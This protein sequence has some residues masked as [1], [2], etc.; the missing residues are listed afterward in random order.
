MTV[1]PPLLIDPA[2]FAEDA[3]APETHACNAEIE[4]LL[5]GRPS[6]ADL[7][8]AKVRELR[9]EGVGLLANQPP[10][11]LAQWET[12]SALGR[13][14]PLRVFRPEGDLRG[15]Y[16]HIHGGGWSIGS[17]DAQDQSLAFLA[18]TLRVGVASVQYRLAPEHP[19]PAG[20]DDCEAAA[21][22]LA[23]GLANALFGTDRMIVGGESAGA[24]LSMV[25][26]LRLKT[27]HGLTPFSGANLLYG[28]YD[29]SQTPSTRA[30]GDRNLI[31]SAPILRYFSE[32][33][34]PPGQRGGL[35]LREPDLSPLYGNLTEL[36]PA[37]LTCGTMDPLLDDTLFMATRWVAAG[38]EAALALYPG[39]IHAFDAIPDL[40]IAGEANA[41][42]ANWL[43][44]RFE[45]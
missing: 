6:V 17:A 35:D 4:A 28:A 31:L 43:D 25:A 45:S 39:G 32:A 12:A 41:R 36:C 3:V 33:L 13:D 26:M 19:W 7:G 44:E 20:A 30:W 1:S 24:H 23:G 38:N 14:V 21:L 11:P 22:A 16:L 42:I 18:E 40:P 5:A 10:H 8:A 2:L 15:V 34:L 9:A 29:M 37:L 27:R